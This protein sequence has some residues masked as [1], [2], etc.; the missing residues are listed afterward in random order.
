MRFAASGFLLGT[1]FALVLAAI[2]LAEGWRLARA[3]KRFGQR[4]QIEAL[5]TARTGTRRAISGVLGCVVVALLFVAAAQPQYGKGTRVL[6]ATNLDVVIVLDFSKSMYARDVSPS[7]SARAKIEV[8]NLVRKLAGAR[9]AAVAFAGESIS[10]PLTS[11]GAA[12]AQFFRGLEPNDLPVGGTAI[13]RALESG[14]QLL[15]RDPLS[16][17]HER[18][19]V[20]ITDGEDLEGDPVSVARDAAQSGIR[21]EVVQIGGQTPEPIPH[22]DERGRMKGMRRDAEGQ[23]MTTELTAE[24]EAQ[25]LQVASEGQGQLVR[26]SAGQTGISQMTT[27]LRRLM[28]EELSER[29]ETVFAD[30]F[31]YP[32]ALAVLLSMIEVWVGTAPHRV[33]APEPPKNSGRKRKP[34]RARSIAVLLCGTLC[35]C[36]VAHS[37]ADPVFERE[38][39]VVNKAILALE[40]QRPEEAEKLLLDYLQTGP[41]EAGVLGLGERARELPD[42][43]FDLA[44]AL[45]ALANRAAKPEPPSPGL[46]PPTTP[47]APPDDE[48]LARIGCGLRLL[49]PLGL[50]RELSAELRARSYYLS[51]N[52]EMLRTDYESAIASFDAGLALAPG[53][54]KGKGD[55]IGRQI[56]KNRA[57]AQRLLKEQK[58]QEKQQNS[59][60]N[61]ENGEEQQ[62]QEQQNEPGDSGDDQNDSGDQG[63]SPDDQKD[64]DD[65]KAGDQQ[66][67]DDDANADP[68][69][70]ADQQGERD[71]KEDEAKPGQPDPSQQDQTENQPGQGDSE[72]SAD[73]TSPPKSASQAS[74]AQ[75]E[76]MLDILEQAPTLQQHEAQEKGRTRVIGRPTMEDK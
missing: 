46:A 61:Q 12:I 23:I 22:I 33:V 39:P 3:K 20:L 48:R 42:G 68:S 75:G 25:L 59:D 2:I 17:N 15:D 31:H 72:S 10:F 5:M 44:L 27:R 28:T 19:M 32:L 30:V 62:D 43:S 73:E 53:L 45:S 49:A 21:V 56:A 76:R 67:P 66:E 50:N 13:A 38:S 35:G 6:P 41:C 70:D 69:S 55:P 60:Q 4:E 40:Q 14:R 18:V 51:G 37:L 54:E 71:E 29:V 26:A 47:E 34:R 36:D 7:R 11:D 64:P 74:A 24:G 9:F 1:L 63:D 58:E 16:K 65:Q 52:L 8:D 57:L